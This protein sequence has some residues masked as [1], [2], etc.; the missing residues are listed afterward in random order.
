M[1]GDADTPSEATRPTAPHVAS[2]SSRRTLRWRKSGIGSPSSDRSSSAFGAAAIT[3]LTLLA[4]LLLSQATGRVMN[5]FVMTDE[6]FYERLGISVAQTG[7]YLPRLHGE[8]IAN[9]NQLY[10]V[11]LSFVFG[12]A[13]VPQS[14]ASA[15]RLNAFVMTSAAIPVYLLARRVS[16]GRL[17]SLWVAGLAIAM[18][19]IVLSSFLLTEV[20]AYPVFCWCLLAL[21]TATLRK[22]ALWDLTALVAIGV[23]VL[24]RAQFAVLL[25]VFAVAVVADAVAASA[26]ASASAGAERRGVLRTAVITLVRTRRVFLAV[27]AVSV[28]ALVVALATGTAT[29]ALGSYS[30]TARGIRV[31]PDLLR[32]TTEHFAVLALACGVLPFVAGGAWLVDRLRPSAAPPE[33]ALALVG[34]A[35]LVLVGLQVASFNQRFGAG[36]VK[37][38]YLFYVLPVV[39]VGLGAALTGRSWPRWWA[40]APP[41][42]VVVTGLAVVPLPTYEKLNVDSPAAILNDEILRLAT[43]VQ[44]AH[45][46]LPLG[47]LVLLGLFIETA[48]FF[49][50]RI[51][52]AALVVLVTGAL[53]GG[54]VYAF[55]RLFAVNGTNGLPITLDQGVVF[56]WVD[57]AVGKEGRVTMIRYPVNSPD[58][59]AGVAYW[60]DA[61]FWNE[62]VVR[63]ASFATDSSGGSAW[64]DAFD[65]E[66]GVAARPLETQYALVH[67]ADVRFRL[68]GQQ[69]AFE[70]GAYV[71]EPGVPSRAE[72]LTDQIYGDGW[73]RPHTPA[74][75][76]VFANPGQRSALTRFV[77]ISIASPTPLTARPLSMT[78]NLTSW[79]GWI[80]PPDVSVDRLISVCV[81]TRGFS[82]VIIETPYVSDVYRDPSRAPLTGET[83]RPVGVLLRWIALANETVAVARCPA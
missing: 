19:W 69:I 66:T 28:L 29:R 76:R 58:Y 56:N 50:R 41:V 11:I 44:W 52:A 17:T 73:T 5:W 36:E 7:S 42:V 27:Y 63:D 13:D 67:G 51:A 16:I 81:P 39:L 79:R 80:T 49:P 31:D 18:P 78:S 21:T 82:D 61:E 2:G 71:F 38:R 70:R 20:V 12:N 3:G 26:S 60:W 45:I 74:R 59:W 62:S 10:P 54:A 8:L 1:G 37:D 72:W 33:R 14:L 68:A 40:W 77:T 83:D 35:T 32:L 53:P 65:R 75:I 34:C 25:I 4:G 24:A 57:R 23:A 6:L 55:D 48:I 43:S 30:V 64:T 46:L 22:T 47:A 15:H 9:V